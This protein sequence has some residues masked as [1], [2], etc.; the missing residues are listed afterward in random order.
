MFLCYAK[1][2][3]PWLWAIALKPFALL[4]FFS[5]V[6]A[7]AFALYK[8]FPAGPLRD[9]LFDRTL[10]KRHPVAWTLLVL[11]VWFSLIASIGIFSQQ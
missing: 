6:A 8:L 3:E 1:V 7:I 9:V 5:A 4:A 11:G 10:R 2:M